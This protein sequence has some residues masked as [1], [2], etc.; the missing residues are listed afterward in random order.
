MPKRS[1]S[2]SARARRLAV[3]RRAAGRPSRLAS[4][5]E[6]PVEADHHVI[7]HT[8]LGQQ[9]DILEKR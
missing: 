8:G 4:V 9:P 6:V 2:V 1:S 7:E 5:V 3:S